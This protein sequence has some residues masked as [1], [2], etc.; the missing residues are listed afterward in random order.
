VIGEP[1]KIDPI[2]QGLL[3][4]LPPSG[5]QWRMADRKLWLELLEGSFELIYEDVP[6]LL[7]NK[8][9]KEAAN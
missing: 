6:E 8:T 1:P 9:N 4:R 3:G 5:S 7:P 2:I